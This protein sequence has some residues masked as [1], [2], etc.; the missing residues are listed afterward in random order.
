MKIIMGKKKKIIIKKI[1][2]PDIILYKYKK[3]DWPYTQKEDFQTIVN[4]ISENKLTK[5]F[6]KF[7]PNLNTG[8]L[9]EIEIKPVSNNYLDVYYEIKNKS[10]NKSLLIGLRNYSL[11][12]ILLIRENRVGVQTI[13]KEYQQRV[14]A[15]ET[16]YKIDSNI[17]AK[18]GETILTHTCYNISSLKQMYKIPRPVIISEFLEGKS[19]SKL[20]KYI[21]KN[22]TEYSPLIEQK[23]MVII[24]EAMKPYIIL[25][26][27]S[28]THG[29]GII[30]ADMSIAN[31]IIH[32]V[33]YC[34]K[35][36]DVTQTNRYKILRKGNL[37]DFIMM[38]KKFHAIERRPLLNKKIKTGII[39]PQFFRVPTELIKRS[40]N[41]VKEKINLHEAHYE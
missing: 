38:L 33:T 35:I 26:M 20:I 28:Y 29:R 12:D 21:T 15:L 22:Y 37:N 8:A 36:G 7:Y 24:K 5:F 41:E 4:L 30:C 39:N 23:I 10:L 3:L 27:K 17:C 34:C 40:L 19:C 14:A 31:I 32:P 25:F 9:E 13:I 2:L 6:K 18:P 16:I 1:F 11:K